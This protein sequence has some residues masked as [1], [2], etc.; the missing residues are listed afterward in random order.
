M[1]TSD[2]GARLVNDIDGVIT[3]CVK[4][5]DG[6]DQSTRRALAGLVAH[7]LSMSQ[8]QRSTFVQEQPKRGKK[9]VSPS[10]EVDET[11]APADE[12][13]PIMTPVEMLTQLSNQF[14]RLH[15]TRRTRA[16]IM[17]CYAAL[18]SAL[19]VDWVESHYGLVVSHL[20]ND[21]VAN[22]RNATTRHEVLVVRKGVEIL[23][24]ELVG[25]RM[26]G[27]QAQI[28]AIQELAG[29]FLK[30]WPA[31]LAGQ[32]APNPLCLVVAL[33]EV[34]G[35]LQQLGNAPPLVQ[36]ALVDPLLT[37]LAHP[38]HTVR[39]NAA[40]ALRCFCHSTPLRL[41]KVL[42]SAVELLQRDIATLSTPTAPTD[43]HPRALGHAYGVAALLAVVPSRPLYVS[44]DIS[45]RV[46]DM[47]VQLLKRAG[48]HEVR[49]ARTEVEIAWTSVAALMTLGPNFVRAHL[50]QL[51]VL[52][53]NALPKP[54]TKDAGTARSPAEWMFLMH[55]RESALGAV[56]CFLKYNSPV[57]VT[58]DVTRRIA[59]L[60]SNSLLFA[61]SFQTRR[62]EET[63][64]ALRTESKELSLEGREALLRSRIFQCFS[65]LG[66]SAVVDST[67][68][69]LLQSTVSLFA[70]PE[71]YAGSSLQAAIASSTGSFTSIW[72]NTDGY[73][74][75]VSDIQI[76][77]DSKFLMNR[78]S[79]EIAIEVS[80]GLFQHRLERD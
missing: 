40:W 51:L 39:V 2:D 76:D 13:K 24:R 41:P 7:L 55:L 59:S 78:D 6:A 1:Y 69:A 33:R 62:T 46:F 12:M 5:L 65:L 31:L 70:S 25:V 43:I 77:G 18:L 3:Q 20:M 49:I 38:N 73:A 45:A 19:G 34:A 36:D 8:I 52:W 22:P 71:G 50:P 58:P 61:N 21:L 4:S 64:D 56:Y 75:G 72:Q 11:T 15:A 80:V 66:H 29:S 32:M 74:Y 48:E 47:A 27:E 54:T 23:L 30:R 68:T 79:I 53:R 16:G 35:L 60:L 9:G 44:H 26:L 37:L 10:E 17:E 28:A 63:P 57:L 14:N 67:Q 42:L